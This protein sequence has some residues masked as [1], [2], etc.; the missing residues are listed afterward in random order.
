[1]NE[2]TESEKCTFAKNKLIIAEDTTKEEWVEIGSKLNLIEGSVQIWIGDWARF[3]EKKGYYTSSTTYDEISAITG[4]SKKTIQ[5][6][7]YVAENISSSLRKEDLNFSQMALIAPL[8]EDQQIKYAKEKLPVMKLKRKI[9]YEKNKL[10]LEKASEKYIPNDNIQVV[11]DDF[12]EY[13][14]KN[15]FDNSIDAIITDPPYAEEYIPLWEDLFEEAYR[16]LKPSKFLVAYSGHQHLDKIFRIPNKLIYYWMF[17]LDFTNKPIAFGRNILASWK[18][19]LIY[20]KPPFSRISKIMEDKVYIIT[21]FNYN[22]RETHEENW[23][24]SLGNFEYLID[25]FSNPGDLIFEPFA[26]TGTTLVAAQRMRRRCIGVEIEE[27][28]YKKIIEGR[29]AKNE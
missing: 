19:V 1:M 11:Y 6:Y 4:Y 29:L 21:P 12:Y 2:V 25:K 15:I 16:I 8:P 7:K 27:E 9:N 28:K 26:G 22:K 3:G 23:G 5:N 20:Q 14:K 17:K 10:I 13:S 18:S 24:Q